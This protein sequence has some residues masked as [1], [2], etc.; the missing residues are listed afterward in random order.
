MDR[1]IK[2]LTQ[3]GV[4]INSNK[5]FL[6]VS[7]NP[8]NINGI[9]FEQ[10]VASAQV[11]S[12]I[13]LAA[14]GGNGDT[15]IK[16]KVKTR[17]HS[18]LMLQELGASIHFNGEISVKPLTRPLRPFEITVPG[19]PS[20]SAFFA[21]AAALI[22]NSSITIKNILANP[23]RIGFYNILEQMG[24]GVEWMNLRK[25]C[26]ELVGDVHVYWKP[27]NGLDIIPEVVPS[28]IDEIPII[29][30]LA[31]QADGITTIS[32]ADELRVK[33]CD[34]INA[35]CENLIAMGGDVIEKKDGLIISQS[36]IL[37][38]T[39]INTYGDHRIAMSF[40]IAGLLTED[41]NTLDNAE[42]INISFP[43]FHT[44]LEQLIV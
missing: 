37:H 15:Y 31:T 39:N 19:D 30:I 20:S 24:G 17:D 28:V 18:E 11:K 10:T 1:I 8:Q 6:P 9:S 16:E 25:E 44:V 42:C 38:N 27:L 23:T 33:E 34:R 22:P 32:G 40:M 4:E 21:A 3:M 26:G 35:I 2:P 12:C 29:S 13:I 43:E 41:M 14:L 5:G 36:N 7:V